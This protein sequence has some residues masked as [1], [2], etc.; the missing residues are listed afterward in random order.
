MVSEDNTTVIIVDGD[1]DG[2]PDIEDKCPDIPGT[3]TNT[4]CPLASATTTLF[5]SRRIQFETGKSIIK[6][7]SAK[8]LDEVAEVLKQYSYYSLQIDGYCD[9]T[10]AVGDALQ[11]SRDRANAVMEYMISVGIPSIGLSTTGYASDNPITDNNT[12]AGRAQN[13]RAELNLVLK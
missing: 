13:R 12:A 3:S 1:K 5:T 8:I 11:L 10:E 9:N 4:G 2:V 7:V 6:P